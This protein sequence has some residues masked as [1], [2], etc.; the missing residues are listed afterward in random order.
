MQVQ[1]PFNRAG[2]L[3]RGGA[4]LI[5]GTALALAPAAT[6]AVPDEDLAY[7][8][9]LI[10]VE[11]LEIDFQTHALASGKLDARAQKVLTGVLAQEKAHLA[12]LSS[13]V[14]GAGQVAAT[15]DDV[16][17]AYPKATFSSPA[18]VATAAD[19]IESLSLGAYLGAVENVQ[20]PRWRLPFGQ[21]AASEAQHVA[22]LADAAGK[23]V[24]G[25]AFA[26]S[27][28]IDAVSAAL[29]AYES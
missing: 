21:I 20:T 12:G 1:A 17:F 11:L 4:L 16:D 8:R 10:G 18:N 28:Q 5:G 22:A 15:A 25:R 13:L 23:P 7:A 19:A 3:R 9:L 26:P 29:D 24:L 2:L 14:T 27:L 6:A